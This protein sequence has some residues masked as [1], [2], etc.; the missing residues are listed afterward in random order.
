[1][2]P[3]F[4]GEFSKINRFTVPL[5]PKNLAQLVHPFQGYLA[6]MDGLELTF[7]ELHEIYLNQIA[8]S[9]EKTFGNTL[10]GEELSCLSFWLLNETSNKGWLNVR[11]AS[12]LLHTLK[13]DQVM[14]DE[15]G[16]VTADNMTLKSFK[17]EFNFNLEQKKGELIKL[18]NEE[19]TIIRFDLV[20]DIFLERGL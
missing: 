7:D 14:V 1:M 5:H 2:L 11:E 3:E 20:R 9:Y 6:H 10:L 17:K 15:R 18:E 4:H 19:D 8:S 16:I 13:F 12:K